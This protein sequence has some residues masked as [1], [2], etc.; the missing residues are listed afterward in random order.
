M[1]SG[2]I[3]FEIELGTGTK[4][5]KLLEVEVEYDYSPGEEMV[6]YYPDGSG[7]PGSP[8]EIEFTDVLIRS[9]EGYTRDGE[10]AYHV[11]GEDLDSGWLALLLHTVWVWM[12][13][14]EDHLH[15]WIFDEMGDD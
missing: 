9:I 4:A 8:P 10:T 2:S 12:E 5:W 3:E 6:M 15:E 1:S 7:Y 13:E 11:D 14:N